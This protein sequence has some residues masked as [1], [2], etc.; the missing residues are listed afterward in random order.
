MWLLIWVMRC[1]RFHVYLHC[2][3]PV[4]SI[5]VELCSILFIMCL[6]NTK[7]VMQNCC[8]HSVTTFSWLLW[9]AFIFQLVK[10]L[11]QPI[12][13]S[14]TLL[15]SKFLQLVSQLLFFFLLFYS[16]LLMLLILVM[17]GSQIFVPFILGWQTL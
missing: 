13:F 12:N 5:T 3:Y 8:D 2:L 7:L 9:R 1:N 15:W 11:V 14:S 10:I 16:L 6:E 17:L 4:R